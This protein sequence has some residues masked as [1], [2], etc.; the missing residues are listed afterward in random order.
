MPPRRPPIIVDDPDVAAIRARAADLQDDDPSDSEGKPD[1]R[2]PSNTYAVY[3]PATHGLYPLETMIPVPTVSF[4]ELVVDKKELDRRS[5][6]LT[7]ADAARVE[8][9]V[10][11]FSTNQEQLSSQIRNERDYSETL[12]KQRDEYALRNSETERR[13]NE[14]IRQSEDAK[15]ERERLQAEL[16][17]AELMNQR[18][19]MEMTQR[20]NVRKLELDAVRQAAAPVFAAA[21]MGVSKLLSEWTSKNI[22]ASAAPGLPAQPGANGA[23]GANGNGSASHNSAGEGPPI[24]V[25]LAL[26]AEWRIALQ[27]VW[28]SLSPEADAHVRAILASTLLAQFGAPPAPE[29]VKKV[30]FALVERDAGQDKI[31]DLFTTTAQAYVAEEVAEAPAHASPAPN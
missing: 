17:R 1:R 15:L 29:E 31:R 9:L 13:L 27:A 18:F 11:G 19:D 21:G 28:D 16:R 10:I 14:M 4:H 7:K 22:G 26:T 23:N 24:R 12:R 30:L 20:T 6:D 8:S 2:A 5:L 3:N 25:N